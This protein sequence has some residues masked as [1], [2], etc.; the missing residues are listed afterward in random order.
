MKFFSGNRPTASLLV[1]LTAV[2]LLAQTALYGQAT[3]TVTGVVADTTGASIPKATV[4]LTDLASGIKR[5]ATSSGDGAFAFAGVIPDLSYQITVSADNFEPWQSQPFAVHAGDKLSYGDIKMKVGATTAAVTVEAHG[6]F[7]SGRARHWRAQ[8]HHHRQGSE[9][10]HHRRPRRRRAGQDV[11]RIRDVD[12]A[13]RASS[14]GLDTT[15]PSWASAAPL[16]AYVANGSGPAGIAIVSDGVSLT[17]IATNSGS[18]QQMNIE[19]VQNVKASSSSY[20]PEYAKGPALISSS[21]K[22]GGATLSRRGLFGGA[23][24]DLELQRLV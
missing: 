4:S 9:Q 8:R 20:G 24:C 22:T 5:T 2:L 12:R 3:G 11:A 1:M 6:R 17:D 14:T 13:T 7:Q 18:V 23:Q 19:M 16:S 21:T 15:T 10:S